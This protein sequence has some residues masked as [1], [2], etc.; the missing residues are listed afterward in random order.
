MRSFLRKTLST[1]TLYCMLCGVAVHAWANGQLDSGALGFGTGGRIASFWPTDATLARGATK[2]VKTLVQADNKALVI[3]NTPTPFGSQFSGNSQ[4]GITRFTASGNPDTNYGPN[5]QRLLDAGVDY[6]VEAVDAVL[7]SDGALLVLGT[8]YGPFEQS[9]PAIWAV[10]PSGELDPA[11]AEAGFLRIVR[12]GTPSDRAGAIVKYD[13]SG[14]VLIAGDFRDGPQGNHGLMQIFIFENTGALC[15]LLTC[16]NVVGG[17]QAGV[18]NWRML[19]VAANFD[20]QV[21][22]LELFKATPGSNNATIRTLLRR[23]TTNAQGEFDGLVVG[24][25]FA[26]GGLELDPTFG[27]SSSGLQPYFFSQAS[28]FRYNNGNKMTLQPGP[29]GLRLV[30]AGFIANAQN[31]DPSI[32]VY[33][34]NAQTGG[35][36]S[37]F[38]GGAPKVFDYATPT[39]HGDAYADDILATPDGKILVGG[40][41][42]YAGFSFGDAALTRLN[43]DGSFD[44][45]FGNTPLIPGRVG[46]GHAFFGND[47]DNRLASMALS[48]DGEKVVFSG[49][50]YTSDDGSYF[51]SVMRAKLYA[52]NLLKNGFEGGP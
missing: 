12:S 36:D 43:V 45:S 49:F 4:I 35:A 5:G 26:G 20:V 19:R 14:G 6:E 1:L 30:I 17:T 34:M 48:A 9:F 28:G 21:R 8:I 42:E 31:L 29:N 3:S 16:G 37:S 2:P 47:R 25:R 52:I 24:S 50:A 27:P 32:G 13:E 23:S 40:G 22:D 51:A 33:A 7:R 41:Y 44:S 38:N 46:Y 15:G 39:S 18:G 11:F 10:L